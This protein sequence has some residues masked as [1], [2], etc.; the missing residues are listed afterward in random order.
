MTIQAVA[1]AL[2][3][4]RRNPKGKKKAPRGTPH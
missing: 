1:T 3:V 4:A 2:D